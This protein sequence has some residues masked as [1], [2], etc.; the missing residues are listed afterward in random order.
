MGVPCD[1][2]RFRRVT[3]RSRRDRWAFALS[4][5]SNAESRCRESF[6]Q[7]LGDVARYR[8]YDRE[9]KRLERQID[10]RKRQGCAGDAGA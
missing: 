2:A 7:W 5:R 9:V 3:G 6:T 1:P 8:E 10:Q 4:Q